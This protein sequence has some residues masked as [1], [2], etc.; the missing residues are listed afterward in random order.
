[1]YKAERRRKKGGEREGRKK[2]EK[3]AKEGSRSP[4]SRD[5]RKARKES[6][7]ESERRMKWMK[8]EMKQGGGRERLGRARDDSKVV[9]NAKRN[10]SSSERDIQRREE[11]KKRDK[12]PCPKRGCKTICNASPTRV[13][14]FSTFRSS[15]PATQTQLDENDS[16]TIRRGSFSRY[17]LRFRGF[18][19][20]R[21]LL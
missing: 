8:S 12:Q 13:Q 5:R 11:R 7:S 6:E 10:Q 16:L 14:K 15:F 9:E 17:L 19:Y 3:R 2:E 20:P 4:S 1:M 21:S 18:L